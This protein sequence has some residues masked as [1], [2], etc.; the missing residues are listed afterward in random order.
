LPLILRP[1]VYIVAENS[2]ASN[3]LFLNIALKYNMTI[4][5]LSNTDVRNII[6]LLSNKSIQR[7]ILLYNYSAKDRLISDDLYFI[8]KNIGSIRFVGV[9]GVE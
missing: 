3:I 4:F 1:R 6:P 5:D 2:S 7:D 8:E 9:W